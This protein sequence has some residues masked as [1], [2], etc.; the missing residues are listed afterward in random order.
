MGTDGPCFSPVRLR[1]MLSSGSFPANDDGIDA[2]GLLLG[3]DA[4]KS[5]TTPALIGL[6]G[7]LVGYLSGKTEPWKGWCAWPLTRSPRSTPPLARSGWATTSMTAGEIEQVLVQD[8]R[9]A[10]IFGPPRASRERASI[11]RPP[12]PCCASETPSWPLVTAEMGKPLAEA[13]P[14]SRSAPGTASTTPSTPA[15]SWP[16]SR[17]GQRTSAQL[18]RLRAARHGAGDHAVELPVLAGVPLRRAGADGRQRGA[19]QARLERHRGARSP[20]RTSSATP[21]A[22]TGVFRDAPGRRAGRPDASTG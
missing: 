11:L 1:Q 2:F 21:A 14:R 19:A 20:S 6:T 22:R 12:R 3:S 13:G 16:T 9:R 17:C 4:A 10:G 18:G 15:R 5:I 7:L 8:D